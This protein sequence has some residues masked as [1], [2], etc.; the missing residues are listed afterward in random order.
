MPQ[1]RDRRGLQ[2]GEAQ[3]QTATRALALAEAVRTADRFVR[4]GVVPGVAM[5]WQKDGGPVHYHCV[6]ELGF[7]SGAPVD[8]RS[9]FRIFSMTKPVAGIAAMMLIEDGAMA[10]DQP[11]AEILPEFRAMRVVVGDDPSDTRP[12]RNPI[13]IRH[14]LTHTAGF[15][16]AGMTLGALYLKHGITPGTRERIA[17]PGELP[18]PRTL[19]ELGSRLATLPLAA[20]P[21]T[22]F[23]Y[24]VSLDVL[25]LAVETVAGMGFDT[26][27]Q[28]RLFGPLG[29]MD[30]GFSVGA[31]QVDR[32]ADL[33]EQKGP[34]W[35]L[36]DD[37]RHSR[38]SRP[39][40]PSG[41]GGLVSTAHDY[42]RFAAMLLNEGELDGVRVLKPETVRQAK[43]NLLPAGVERIELP[44]GQP[45]AGAG[46]GAGMSVQ[47]E[48]GRDTDGMFAWPGAV[49]AGVF[50]WPGA[51]GTAAWIDPTARFFL[52]F[53]TQYWPSWL[54]PQMR[55]ELIAAA[56]RDIERQP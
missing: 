49:P 56:Y 41:G 4:E 38:Y 8:E 28:E 3:A 35:T 55:P 16:S 40:F 54:N 5:A 51:A 13:T 30:T 24:S 52:V 9:I 36:A 18:T 1:G 44:L 14:L 11:L 21:G 2:V 42:A 7:Q 32:F 19:A 53:L 33:P 22:R 48:P 29:M 10:L 27:L 31:D 20:E 26:F 43:S 47:V 50:G 12:A 46:F 37:P 15:G 45:L 25:G 23:D 17:G 6:G 39:Y 34:L